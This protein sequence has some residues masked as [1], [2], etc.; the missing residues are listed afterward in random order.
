MQG[1][2]KAATQQATGGKEK[3]EFLTLLTFLPNGM[4]SH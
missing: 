1:Y 2:G 4:A 3:C